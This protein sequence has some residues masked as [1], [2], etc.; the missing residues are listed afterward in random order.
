[1]KNLNA[2]TYFKNKYVSFLFTKPNCM[3]T[4]KFTIGTLVGGI[5]F[6]FL[7]YLVYGLLLSSFFKQHSIAVA[8]SMKTMEELIWWA[9]ILGNLA[10]GAL[11]T[12]IF[13]KLGNVVSFSSGARLGLTIGFFL[14]LSMDLIRYATEN[15]SDMTGTLTDVIVESVMGAIAGGA[16]AA[17]L[18][19]GKRPE[20]DFF[21]SPG[22][23]TGVFYL[24]QANTRYALV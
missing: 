8:G 20:I 6:F 4:K 15:G 1:M 12:Y 24:Y 14:S 23:R 21:E 22:P 9:L 7:G 5:V 10:S 17:V 2:Y 16:I 3:D 18:G 13:L 19:R 11:L